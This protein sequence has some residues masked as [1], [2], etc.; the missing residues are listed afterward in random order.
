MLTL[1]SYSTKHELKLTLGELLA[2]QPAKFVT[3]YPAKADAL[4]LSWADRPQTDVL[5]LARF[6]KDFFQLMPGES[7]VPLRKSRLLLYLNTFRHLIPEY[8]NLDFGTF[9]SAYQVFSDL[10]AYTNSPELPDEVLADLDPEVASLAQLFHQ[11]C[12]AAG[13]L[14]EHAAIFEL[15][16]HLRAPEGIRLASEPVLVFDG[17][18]FMTPAQLS[19]LE[20]LAIRHKVIVPIPQ[21][22]L[23]HAHALDWPKALE[24]A[25]HEIK[26]T[27]EDT[28]P[29]QEILLASYP[30][31]SLGKI[32]SSWREQQTGD[33]NVVLGTKHEE[34]DF[35]QE[36][37]FS[38]FVLKQSVD[39]TADT[40][41]SIFERWERQIASFGDLPGS[42][43]LRWIS[44]DKI[45]AIKTGALEKVKEV[46]VLDSLKNA[47]EQVPHFFTHQK[48]DRFLMNLLRE[49]AGLDAPRNSLISLNPKSN[50]V[51]VYNLKNFF[52]LSE[53]SPTVLCLGSQYGS[54][55]SDHR[56][57]SNELEKKLAKLGPVRRPELEFLFVQVELREL[58]RH[59]LLTVVCEEGLL[60]HDLGWKRFFEGI[61]V[62]QLLIPL[63][64]ESAQ[65][66]YSFFNPN[67]QIS[68]VPKRLSASRLQ[69]YL[70]CPRKYFADRIEKIV[71][72]Y[73]NSL[74]I[75]PLTM[76]SIEHKLVE[77]AWPKGEG[78][79]E[80]NANLFQLAEEYVSKHDETNKLARTIR[81]AAINEAVIY[82]L[83]G[84]RYL[85]RLRQAFPKISFQFEYELNLDDRSGFIDCIGF[86]D[87]LVLLLDFKRSK[88]QNP[89]FGKWGEGY[90]KI[91][92]WFYLNA[93]RKM[94]L[95][96]EQT[97]LAVGYLFFKDMDES[98]LATHPELVSHLEI[99][100]PKGLYPWE[101]P[102]A[103]SQYSDFEAQ[104][105]ERLSA[106]SSFLP[107]PKDPDVCTNCSVRA[108]CPGGQVDEVAL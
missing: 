14:D 79:W 43:L 86:A 66:G 80:N 33:V 34:L 83:N 93:L 22:V 82:A 84:L 3:P 101:H 11:G 105:I 12:N 30:K 27:N 7:R 52:A 106:D 4:R 63:K 15:T 87:D 96:R 5:T 51:N 40:R 92:L 69:D 65:P 72:K 77:L 100:F 57:Y 45:A 108:V 78:W 91:Q 2:Q 75:N 104:A 37:P 38:D 54:I 71:P 31:G 102:S 10:R 19:L 42:E 98:W 28:R 9:K 49:V 44:E 39:V 48:L 95:L 68:E 13:I 6:L 61:T 32:L 90:P 58:L 73:E 89:S 46:A 1:L 17:F 107:T 47:I 85:K 16:H 41:A 97:K 23:T 20:A 36:I 21:Q 29:A 62:K 26:Q 99:F 55:K 81:A 59:P 70:D 88:G 74:E 56:P 64:F 67:V 24:L 8:R 53:Q 50:G 35:Y 18:T 94:N 76:G 103:L 60:K 25:S